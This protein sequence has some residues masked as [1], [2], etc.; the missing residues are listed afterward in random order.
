M[1]LQ[2]TRSTVRA[3]RFP[4]QILISTAARTLGLRSPPLRR[5][6][7]RGPRRWR[8]LGICRDRDS[9]RALLGAEVLS[10]AHAASSPRS[11]HR[12]GPGGQ[13]ES[14]PPAT[15]AGRGSHGGPLEYP[16]SSTGNLIECASESPWQTATW[17]PPGPAASDSESPG[18]SRLGEARRRSPNRPG[19]RRRAEPLGHSSSPRCHW[20]RARLAAAAACS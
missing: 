12:R 5:R 13:V 19:P 1:P 4:T 2:V 11:E 9:A 8:S 16:L 20:P 7:G 17:T 10:W 14:I 3:P 6:P 15:Q 18:L